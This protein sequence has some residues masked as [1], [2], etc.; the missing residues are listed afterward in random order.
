MVEREKRP[1]AAFQAFC[2]ISRTVCGSAFSPGVFSRLN[3]GMTGRKAY[4]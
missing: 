1:I 3:A 2:I 4:V